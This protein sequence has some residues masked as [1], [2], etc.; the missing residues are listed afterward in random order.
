MHD[1]HPPHPFYP[2]HAVAVAAPPAERVGPVAVIAAA[3]GGALAASGVALLLLLHQVAE[4]RGAAAELRGAAAELRAERARGAAVAGEGAT[5][6]PPAVP[7][8]SHAALS[9]PREDLCAI[10]PEGL[11]LLLSPEALARSVR[12]VPRVVDGAPRGLAL[13]GLRAGSVPRLL[14]LK[15]GDV[16]L[17]VNG[18]ALTLEVAARLHRELV[19]APRGALVVEIER[20]GAR[21]TKTFVVGDAG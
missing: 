2:S 7:M 10:H 11:A 9:C 21:L 12:A 20:R 16:V 3:L 14:G 13:Y 17:T 8:I 1:L 15:N 19:A 5:R 4:L 18:E 6:A